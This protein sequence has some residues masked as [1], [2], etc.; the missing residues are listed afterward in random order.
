MGQKRNY[1][2]DYI[3]RIFIRFTES[4]EAGEIADAL[5]DSVIEDIVETADADNWNNSDI[6]I[7]L[8]RIMMKTFCEK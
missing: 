1:I 6:D 8:S 3:Y 4:R 7:A 5:T 2:N